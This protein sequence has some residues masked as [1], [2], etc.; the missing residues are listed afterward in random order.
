V[1][2]IALGLAGEL[3]DVAQRTARAIDGLMAPA[4][5][6]IRIQEVHR[7]GAEHGAAQ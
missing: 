7:R 5:P 1:L 3:L 6:A 2:E 4:L